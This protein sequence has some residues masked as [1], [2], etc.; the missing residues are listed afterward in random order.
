MGG[1]F[2]GTT[3]FGR[4]TAAFG[5]WFTADAG[6]M[7]Y[8]A[9]DQ[10]MTPAPTF[11]PFKFEPRR[12]RIDWRLLHGVDINSMVRDVDLDTLEKIVNIVAFGDIEAEDTRHLTEL[13]FIKIFRLAQMMIEY[14]L[15]VQDCL[16]NSNAWLQQDRSNMDKYVQAARL[17]I[18]ELD[19][20]L[21]MN[22]RELRR[23][24][25]TIKTYELLAVL[26]DGKNMKQT[27]QQQ[28]PA[29]TV[30]VVPPAAA[31]QPPP[32]PQVV[33]IETNPLSVA[34]DALLRKEMS[35][36][37]ERLSRAMV[38]CQSLR[39]ERDDLFQAVKELEATVRRGG[40]D[41]SSPRFAR[42]SLETA[43]T[44]QAM[45]DQL[46]SA[47][48]E[49]SK[50]RNEKGDL[51]ED[52][53]RVN[54]DKRQLQEEKNKLLAEIAIRPPSTHPSPRGD[55]DDAAPGDNLGGML[56]D[57]ERQKQSL[58]EQLQEAR[59]EVTALQKQLMKAMKATALGPISGM[60]S[61]GGDD[62][63]FREL[64]SARNQLEREL[65]DLR[66]AYDED[67]RQLRDDLDMAQG[68]AVEAERRV[69]A[70]GGGLDGRSRVSPRMSGEDPR[71]QA[72]TMA[73]LE[74][75]NERLNTQLTTLR[76]E[77]GLMAADI[78][79]MR[80]QLQNRPPQSPGDPAIPRDWRT[81]EL[82]R[83]KEERDM[84]QRRTRELEDIL[85]E[86][87]GLIERMR[88]TIRELQAQL[89]AS[90]RPGS[91]ADAAL[92]RVKQQVAEY[93][94]L[95]SHRK[96]ESFSFVPEEAEGPGSPFAAASAQQIQAA[97]T[98]GRQPGSPPLS[99]QPQT[100]APS[101]PPPKPAEPVSASFTPP[102]P[103]KPHTQLDPAMAGRWLRRIPRPPPP[104]ADAIQLAVLRRLA[105]VKP[106]ALD[107][108]LADEIRVITENPY[109]FEDD[110]E[111][112]FRA[113]M[114]HELAERPGVLSVRPHDLQDL[115]AAR[116]L[117]TDQL[118][119]VLDD[120]I[121]QY[122]INVGTEAM[123]DKTYAASMQELAA[124]R[125]KVLERHSRDVQER[126]E[127]LRDALLT[128]IELYKRKEQAKLLAEQ[129]KRLQE[130]ADIRR[131]ASDARRAAAAGGLPSPLGSGAGAGPGPG[132]SSAAA[133]PRVSE[134]EEE[135]EDRGSG[136][137]RGSGGAAPAPPRPGFGGAGP[138]P[139]GRPGAGPAAG[140]SGRSSAGSSQEGSPR[141]GPDAGPRPVMVGGRGPQPAQK[142]SSLSRS[143][144]GDDLGGMLPAAGGGF[145]PAGGP[146][147]V[148]PSRSAGAGGQAPE[149]GRRSAT[150]SPL[151]R[152][153]R[154]DGSAHERLQLSRE[155]S[156]TGPSAGGPVLVVGHRAPPQQAAQPTSVTVS[157][158]ATPGGNMNMSIRSVKYQ[159][160]DFDDEDE[161]VTP[162]MPQPKAVSRVQAQEADEYALTED[163]E[164]EEDMGIDDDTEDFSPS[165]G[166][167]GPRILI[168]PPAPASPPRPAQPSRLGP[169]R[170]S[171]VGGSKGWATDE[172]LQLAPA[173]KPAA[174]QRP[175]D[176][177]TGDLESLQ[178]FGAEGLSQSLPRRPMGW[179]G[180]ALQKPSAPQPAREMGQQQAARKE[181]G[182]NETI[183]SFGASSIQGDEIQSIEDFGDSIR[184]ARGMTGGAW[185]A[186]AQAKAGASSSQAGSGAAAAK[187]AVQ[188]QYSSDLSDLEYA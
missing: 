17:R 30:T 122:G 136:G 57:A 133:K 137:S 186:P 55:G 132:P 178:S 119:A 110:D 82:D 58:Q 100:M 43:Q 175:S 167:G 37:S 93:E 64:E 88:G 20:N 138:G 13:N 107:M 154:R 44:L 96:A 155:G 181:S 18:R 78:E 171:A 140:R 73:E 81:E 162:I 121:A 179:G 127:R 9:R 187:P 182:L 2:G 6:G 145:R 42:N 76:E 169:Q 92:G 49:I 165:G 83:L 184:P 103:K 120:E 15:Y 185:G 166:G 131:T 3:A 24:R 21:K 123:D 45:Q 53:E 71:R 87:D 98:F 134:I 75:T 85:R 65:L 147:T 158:A 150:A 160:S 89:E 8:P 102:S 68:R 143:E 125:S 109:E 11:P 47:T 174:S 32:P 31:P 116:S 33:K 26:N 91:A 156:H 63:T 124:R 168:R 72:A 129:Q 142:Q 99:A 12:S 180:E 106:E 170:T 56:L 79:R 41:T 36:L 151:D 14:L 144:A 117:L 4:T 148:I 40:F 161:D 35:T 27:M 172:P 111:A 112:H 188:R 48:V 115:E 34:M 114:K 38:E 97:P 80:A 69:R 176:H 7:D 70:S 77:R 135:G 84:Y 59:E 28:Q 101:Q 173:P 159:E 183:K 51:L 90:A 153:L 61:S 141:G 54:A 22:K 130:E 46:R 39:A 128:H 157:A 164:K 105:G 152:S 62:R 139:S 52:F 23:T 50:L 177:D 86:R 10:T 19:A 25:K 66:R 67:V 74:A 108:M 5:P 163:E 149:G 146:V 95:G 113:V 94:R 1:G 60:P 126:A 16:Q 118:L 104:E 29:A